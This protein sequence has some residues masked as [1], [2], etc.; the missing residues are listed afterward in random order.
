MVQNLLQQDYTEYVASNLFNRRG[1]CHAEP[2]LVT[3]R[4]RA[5]ATMAAAG[6]VLVV[7][8]RL[9]TVPAAACG[10]GWC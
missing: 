3:A 5:V 9:A 6:A 2:E 1:L 4:R 10:S 7:Q 8:L